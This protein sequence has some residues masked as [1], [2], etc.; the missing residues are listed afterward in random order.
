M[1]TDFY[2]L[3]A[4]VLFSALIAICVSSIATADESILL[5]KLP[6]NWGMDCNGNTDGLYIIDLSSVLLKDYKVMVKAEEHHDQT[7]YKEKIYGTFYNVVKYKIPGNP[8]LPSCDGKIQF[9]NDA[10]KSFLSGYISYRLYPDGRNSIHGKLELY[11]DNG[12]TLVRSIK[13]KQE[14]E[15]KR[16]AIM[17]AEKW[18]QSLDL[19]PDERQKYFLNTVDFVPVYDRCW[20]FSQVDNRKMMIENKLTLEDLA[21]LDEGSY[22]DIDIKEKLI[23]IQTKLNALGYNPGP[24]DGHAGPITQAAIIKYLNDKGESLTMP[25]D[26]DFINYRLKNESQ[27]MILGLAGLFNK[28]NVLDASPLEIQNCIIKGRG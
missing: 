6:R 18:I 5:T 11:R 23:M 28:I 16:E 3:I 17:S 26:I 24:I 4:L 8:W 12:D 19:A 2:K 22:T 27:R 1:S 7:L 15:N 13:I 9:T 20:P 10:L 21:S 14:L 25:N